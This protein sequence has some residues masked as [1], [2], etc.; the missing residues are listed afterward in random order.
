MIVVDTNVI[1]YLLLDGVHTSTADRVYQR[2]HEWAA[3]LLWRSELRN[4]LAVYGRSTG[5]P[6]EDAIEVM[7]KAEQL[8]AGREFQP[9]SDAVLALAWS[10]GLSAYDC[11]FVAV[12]RA[13]RVPLV[14][15]DRKVMRRFPEDATAAAAFG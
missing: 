14:T 4:V 10:S 2:D 12:A 6:V 13:L 8:V 9:P 1:A 15:F 5:M 3:P 11:E 7:R